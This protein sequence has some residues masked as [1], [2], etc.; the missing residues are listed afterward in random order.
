MQINEVIKEVD[1][2][3][4]AIKYY[5]EAGLL[6][7]AKGENGYREYTEQDIVVLKEIAIYRKLG[8]SIKDIKVLLAG[9]NREL[10]ENIYREKCDA[11][12][13]TTRELD[14]LKSYIKDG[15]VEKCYKEID[16]ATIAKA[17]ED[18]LPGFY[19]YY[20]MNH[21]MPYLQLTIETKEQEIAYEKI[22]NFWD[23][24]DIK[25]PIML[26]INSYIMYRL[27]KPTLEEMTRKMDAQM[28][29]YVEATE[30]E[31]EGLKRQVKR[32]VKLQQN[33]LLKYQPAF[34]AKRK[35]MKRLQDCGYNDIFIPNMIALSPSYKAYHEAMTAM[36][37]RICSELGLYY[38]SNYCLV[39]KKE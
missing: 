4:R 15:D 16:Y 1:L 28:K 30:A 6:Q 31:Y 27:P 12:A 25:I 36:N 10:L 34:I 5:E 39:M 11:L 20:F 8:I 14:A 13:E 29:R 32:G 22:K 23:E 35:W 2:S 26:R 9:E 19:G 18:R 21:F 38:D 37:D 17:L 24:V 3:K 7:V 33:V